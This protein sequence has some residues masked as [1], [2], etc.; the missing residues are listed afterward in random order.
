MNQL[1]HFNLLRAKILEAIAEID[2][3]IEKSN[4]LQAKA[5]KS[6]SQVEGTE[7]NRLDRLSTAEVLYSE[8][9]WRYN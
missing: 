6:A 8:Q 9:H 5:K 3:A 2:G 7:V 1:E 4:Q